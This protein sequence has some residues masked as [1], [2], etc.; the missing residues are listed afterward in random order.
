MKKLFSLFIFL[1]LAYLLNKNNFVLEAFYLMFLWGTLFFNEDSNMKEK[2]ISISIV[3]LCY[4]GEKYLHLGTN[5]LKII[6]MALY[7]SI[8][9]EII[10]LIIVNERF[11]KNKIKIKYILIFLIVMSLFSGIL[12]GSGPNFRTTRGLTPISDTPPQLRTKICENPYF[13]G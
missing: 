13:Q 6:K 3:F 12:I 10:N 9:I 7:L 11:N 5:S 1:L 8:L 2:I 4:I